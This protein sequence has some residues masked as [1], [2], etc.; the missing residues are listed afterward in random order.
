MLETEGPAGGWRKSS[1][2]ESGA[3]VEVRIGPG[4]VLLR[5]SRDRQGQVLAF[6]YSE[7]RAF[8]EGAALGEFDLP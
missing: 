8:L 1:Q 4:E 5:H 3:C 2:S 6:S 7:W